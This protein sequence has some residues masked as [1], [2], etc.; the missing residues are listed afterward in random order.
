MRR[1]AHCASEPSRR[2]ASISMLPGFPFLFKKVH[3]R[4]YGQQ[5]ETQVSVD[6]QISR[7]NRFNVTS[8]ALTDVHLDNSVG[9]GLLDLSLGRTGSSVEDQEPE[10]FESDQSRDSGSTRAGAN[11]FSFRA[12][13]VLQLK[14]GGL[15]RASGHRST[16]AER[17]TPGAFRESRVGA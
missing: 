5:L 8:H 10:T 6:N 13:V 3:T 17:R 12:I 9:D 7:L 2:N 16:I 15:T 11:P 14:D 4:V 1:T